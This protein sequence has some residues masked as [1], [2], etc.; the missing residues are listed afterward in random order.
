VASTYLAEN[1]PEQ[2]AVAIHRAIEVA[3]DSAPAWMARGTF[4]LRRRLPDD[5]ESDIARALELATAQND[6]AIQQAALAGLTDIYLL[7]EDLRSAEQSAA[8]LNSLAPE[9]MTTRYTA[10]RVAFA[11]DDM[12]TAVAL[13]QGILKDSPDF[14]Q[15]HLLYGAVSRAKGNLAQAEMYLASAVAAWPENTESRKLLADVRLRQHKLREAS[16]AIEPLLNDEELVDDHLLATAG[17]VKLQSGEYS[18]GLD[19]FRRSVEAD[20]DN[21]ERKMDLA[22]IYLAVGQADQ[23][24]A[25][26]ESLAGTDVD[27][28]RLDVLTVISLQHQG[29]LDGAIRKAEE[30]LRHSPDD[31]RLYNVIGGIY[32]ESGDL[33]A[34]RSSLEHAL[35]LDTMNIAALLQL[36]SL[37]IAENRYA[38]ARLRYRRALQIVPESVPVIIEMARLAMLEGDAASSVSW[39]EKARHSSEDALLPRIQLA[40]YYL[41]QQR[42]EEAMQVAEEAVLIEDGDARARNLL[43]VTQMTTGDFDSAAE[44]FAEAIRIE[45]EVASYRYNHARAEFKKGDQRAALRIIRENYEAHPGHIPSAVQLADYYMR[46][47]DFAAATRIAVNIQ[48]ILPNN[49]A[50]LALQ[51]DI[52]AAQEKFNDAVRMYDLALAIG[53]SRELAIRAYHLRVKAANP[54]PYQAITSYLESSPADSVAR[55]FLAET[56]HS[57]GY[58]DSAAAEYEQLLLTDPDNVVALNNLAWLL[59]DKGSPR[60]VKL[61]EA[62]YRILPDNGAI[63]DTY[64]WILLKQSQSEKASAVLRKAA[65]AMPGNAE[66]QYH[67][68]VVLLESGNEDEAYAV[69]KKIVASDQT[70][71]S[72]SAAEQLIRRIQRNW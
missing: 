16:E 10:A 50:G 43:G 44:N 49:A 71:A 31:V 33:A 11:T 4:R 20:P 70:F 58:T 36:G 53:Q 57:N 23:A 28:H 64:G 26:L 24:I 55:M 35:R 46:Q 66:I 51:G 42:H 34:A 6:R 67:F 59:L 56:Y 52:L 40:T 12:D 63:A 38:D 65:E 60:A 69:L 61:A 2:A 18:G 37:D 54:N 9:S 14:R 29:D 45:P 25:V 30:L 19:L 68:G 32:E 39:L 13:L 17:V 1:L 62:A 22:T 15:A 48:K 72:R 47:G 7:K 3:P 21:L 5:A 27:R 8:R 41:S